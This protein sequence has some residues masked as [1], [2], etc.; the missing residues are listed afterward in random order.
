MT[1]RSEQSEDFRTQLESASAA[2]ERPA[3]DEQPEASRDRPT[4]ADRSSAT[5]ARAADETSAFERQDLDFWAPNNTLRL[6]DNDPQWV[7]RWITE[8]V[9][10]ARVPQRMNKARQQGWQFVRMSELPEGFYVD[11]DVAGDGLARMGGLV[12]AKLPRRFAEQR[13]AHYAKRS[14][15][16][17]AGANQLQGVAGRD[18]VEENRGTR[19]LDGP[20][21]GNALRQFARG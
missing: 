4:E 20:A 3:G 10:G 8:Y 11:E 1:R 16:M 5:L 6:P 14:Q 2:R 9:N 18:T 13:K 12:M 7:Y 17:L 21:A 15:E 19:S